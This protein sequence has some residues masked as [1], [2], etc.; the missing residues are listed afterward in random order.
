MEFLVSVSERGVLTLPKEVRRR[1]GLPRGGPV[2]VRVT[3]DGVLLVP[4]AAFPIETYTDE[5]LAEFADEESK[6]SKYRLE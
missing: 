4:V 6:L 3:A 1:V 2:S 5:R